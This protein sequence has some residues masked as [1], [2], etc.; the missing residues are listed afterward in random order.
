MVLTEAGRGRANIF[1]QQASGFAGEK[2]L[3]EQ[4]TKVHCWAWATK[5][6]EVTQEC[7]F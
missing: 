4:S 5:L 2:K 7:V 3:Q 6:P 1:L